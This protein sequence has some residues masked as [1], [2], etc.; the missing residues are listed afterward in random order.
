MGETLE[1]RVRRLE[2]RERIQ[3]LCAT[4]CFLVDDGRFD[5]L[6]D[7]CFTEDA[8]C[9]FRSPDGA[10][11]PVVSRGIAEVRQFF[12]VVVPALLRDMSHTVHNHRIR[13]EGDTASGECY[14]E[15]TAVTQAQGE[16]VVGAGRYF[17][18][19]RRTDSGWRFAER[20]AQIAFIAPLQE[21]WAARRFAA[22]LAGGTE[23]EPPR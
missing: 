7:T 16:A 9:D 21:G 17:D 13:L 1:E 3:E 12:T 23:Q 20:N 5:E 10:M 6:T 19:Y 22:G 11:G 15:L 8:G 4:Y 14:F 2:D 18:R